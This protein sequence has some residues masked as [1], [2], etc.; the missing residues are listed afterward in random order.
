MPPGEV[1]SATHQPAPGRAERAF[2]RANQA[3]IVA[4]AS[5]MVVLVIVN[6]FCRYVLNFSLVW[7]EEVSQYLMVWVA[8]L[9]AGLALRQGRHVAVEMLQDRLPGRARRVLRGVLFAAML[10]FF[11][12]VTVLGVQFA[13]FA[14]DMETPVLNISMAIPYAAVPIG[15]ALAA[16]HLVLVAR[17][18]VAGEHEAAPNIE[19]PI[20]EAELE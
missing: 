10:A 6:V 18:Y 11:V 19:P 7:A 15:S 1:A 4:M 8:F 14:H 12:T 3:L 16:A 17:A 13:W 2:V 9:G 5:V 20:D